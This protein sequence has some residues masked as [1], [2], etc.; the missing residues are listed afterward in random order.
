[1]C[2][3]V[4]ACVYLKVILCENNHLFCIHVDNCIVDHIMYFLGQMILFRFDMFYKI[5]DFIIFYLGGA[6]LI[7]TSPDPKAHKVSL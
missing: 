2:V 3:C 6:Y 4:Y 1:M 7:F 5:H